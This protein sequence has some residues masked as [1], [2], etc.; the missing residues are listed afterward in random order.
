MAP[1]LAIFL[2]NFDGYDAVLC[3]VISLNLQ[4]EDTNMKSFKYV[5]RKV[6]LSV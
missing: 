4:A 2:K 3:L 1:N 6:Y 5:R